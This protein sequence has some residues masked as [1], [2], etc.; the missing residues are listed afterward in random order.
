MAA[1]ASVSAE[2]F[3]A[4]LAEAA[5]AATA[6][7]RTQVRQLSAEAAASIARAVARGQQQMDAAAT[8][9]SSAAADE[10]ATRAAAAAAAAE[11]AAGAAATPP[12]RRGSALQTLEHVNASESP[13]DR[14]LTPGR[15]A[16]RS[17]GA[18]LF[19]EAADA[20]EQVAA[21]SALAAA[22][23]VAPG[24]VEGEASAG[25]GAQLER[26]S[27]QMA[28]LRPTGRPSDGWRINL[29][30]AGR[31]STEGSGQ[32]SGVQ[33]TVESVEMNL[34]ADHAAESLRMSPALQRV[35]EDR[36][37]KQRELI[38]AV[39]KPMG[40]E[41]PLTPSRAGSVH[42]SVALSPSALALSPE[43]ARSQSTSDARRRL[44]VEPVEETP[45]SAL[46]SFAAQLP[47]SEQSGTGA[48][49]VAADSADADLSGGSGG[50]PQRNA[51]RTRAEVLLRQM[52]GAGRKSDD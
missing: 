18:G 29:E 30:E 28:R 39:C 9:A 8:A 17:T 6:D 50:R 52:S 16:A 33:Q 38:K 26:V 20:P 21:A 25:E 13:L 42:D 47:Q 48:A 24:D 37:R 1:S 11:R 23:V 4:E 51:I 36:A 5:A 40:G 31:L 27:L 49:G 43:I 46:H 15:E 22:A 44:L 2:R 34:E 3:A 10:S 41:S 14:A 19:P 7:L 45:H 35:E 32:S 12:R